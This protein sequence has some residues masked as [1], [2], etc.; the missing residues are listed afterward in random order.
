MKPS[1]KLFIRKVLSREKGIDSEG[2]PIIILNTV[3][4]E[5]K[6]ANLGSLANPNKNIITFDFV[7]V[8]ETQ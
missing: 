1:H 2:K 7:P 8:E 3:V 5:V 4:D 6:E